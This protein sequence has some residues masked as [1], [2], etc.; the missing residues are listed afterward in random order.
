VAAR[1]DGEA[2]LLQVLGHGLGV[3]PGHDEAGAFALGRADRTEDV[4]PLGS[5]VVRRARASSAPS[6]ATGDPVLLADPGL[7]LP[8][9]FDGGAG[10]ELRLDGLQPGRESF[11]NS[12]S[13]ASF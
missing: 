12:P 10:R 1:I 7:V 4:G 8:P 11:L 9:E 13:A 6:P 3:A 5:L 2:D